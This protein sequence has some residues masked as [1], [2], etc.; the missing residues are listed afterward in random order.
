MNLSRFLS[1]DRVDMALDERFD[2]EHPVDLESLSNHMVDLLARSGDVVNDSKL[3]LD[4]VN[5]ERRAPSLLGHGVALPHVRTLQAR[6]LVMAI[7]ISH[8]G[9]PLDAPDGEPVRLVIALVGP[10]YDDRQYLTAYK[11]LGEAL[12]EDGWVDRLVA[13]EVPGEVLR[14]LSR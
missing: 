1:E 4:L 3:R 13:S 11:R 12:S 7:G 9:L 10:P 8:A 6:K 5:R 2:E 14:A